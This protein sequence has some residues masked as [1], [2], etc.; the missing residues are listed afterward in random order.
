MGE[1]KKRNQ[2]IELKKCTKCGEIKTVENFNKQRQCK[3]G[4]NPRCKKCNSEYQRE[5]RKK[6]PEKIRE[7]ERR[8][9][10]NNPGYLKKKAIEWRT[11]NPEKRLAIDR[12]K[13]AKNPD[14]SKARSVI[15]DL[16]YRGKLKRQ[17]CEICSEPSAEAHHKDYSDPLDIV[18]LCSKHHREEHRRLRSNNE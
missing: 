3:G 14:R 17:P 15:H 1:L 7:Y 4:I 11:N 18:W 8:Y 13:R 2:E 5:Y 6:N 12:R 16:I 10:E 9:I